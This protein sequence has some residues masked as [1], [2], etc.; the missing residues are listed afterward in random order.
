LPTLRLVTLTDDL[1]EDVTLGAVHLDEATGVVTFTGQQ[2]A[3]QQ[4]ESLARRRD[5][6]AMFRLLAEHG[7]SNSKTAFVS[8]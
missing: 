4:F 2:V 1:R 6:A 5:P 8:G 3:R 7:W